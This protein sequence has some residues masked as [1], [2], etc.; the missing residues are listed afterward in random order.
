MRTWGVGAQTCKYVR[1]QMLRLVPL[2]V[3]TGQEGAGGQLW[4]AP[5]LRAPNLCAQAVLGA[6]SRFAD[7]PPT[8]LPHRPALLCSGD[9]Q[10][11]LL[12]VG[13]ALQGMAVFYGGCQAE[14]RVGQAE[15][16]GWRRRVR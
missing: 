13:R 12:A 9:W 10:L 16:R 3:A 11:P 1:P 7:P 5:K 14:V 15:A 6:T 8:A 4:A 2:S